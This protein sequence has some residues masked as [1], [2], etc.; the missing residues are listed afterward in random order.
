M[1]KEIST[2]TRILTSDSLRDLRI[3]VVIATLGRP[4]IVTETVKRIV[5][6]QN[7]Q[8]ERLIISCISHE[9]VG[10][11]VSLA[12]IQIVTG[13]SGLAA[14]RNTALNAIGEDI[15]VIAFFDD[16]FIPDTNW[17]FTAAEL[18]RNESDVVCMTGDVLADGIKGP[19]LSFE[20]A[21]NI[22]RV[23]GPVKSDSLIEP[24]SPYGCNMAFRRSAIGN[25]RFDERLVL[26]GWLE[27]RDFG[28]MLASRGGRFVKCLKARGVHLGVKSGRLSGSRLG[29]SQIVN[30]IY[31]SRKG[32]MS[33]SEAASQIFRN[34]MSNL[35]RALFPE[36]FVDRRGRL[37]GNLSGFYAVLRGKIEP[38]A[39]LQ[40]NSSKRKYKSSN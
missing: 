29:Y 12:A 32:T 1:K 34:F 7:Y 5:K 37:Y 26:Y 6:S 28:A 4:D 25:L 39:V 14:Q 11:A 40:I 16:D 3:A 13:P 31:M 30:P 33:S 22:L 21:D 10:D 9:D 23:A 15:D 2:D 19:G 20:F 35:S 24:F 27:D 38:E 17:L 36:V 8:P 18:F